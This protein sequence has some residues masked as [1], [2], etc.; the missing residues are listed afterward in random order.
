MTTEA[1]INAKP[2]ILTHDGGGQ[3]RIWEVKGLRARGERE[4]GVFEIDIADTEEN[5]ST[6]IR[7]DDFDTIFA[8]AP[9]I[10]MAKLA[11]RAAQGTWESHERTIASISNALQNARNN[12]W[13]EFKAVARMIV[14]VL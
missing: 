8:T 13:A 2:F 7:S 1:A 12:Q 6:S 9:T 10:E 3:I 5:N 14:E 11:R 4:P